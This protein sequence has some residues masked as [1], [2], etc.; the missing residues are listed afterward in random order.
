MSLKQPHILGGYYRMILLLEV[1]GA[2][3]QPGSPIFLPCP[4]YID[5][6][7]KDYFNREYSFPLGDP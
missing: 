1:G 7:S 4:L 2:I 6:L 3:Y 5:Y